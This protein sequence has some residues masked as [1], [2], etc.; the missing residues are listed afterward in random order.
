[1]D[2]GQEANPPT[3]VAD[4]VDDHVAKLK[5]LTER[6]QRQAGGFRG[7]RGEVRSSSSRGESVGFRA[8]LILAFLL[9]G[10]GAALLLAARS[11]PWFQVTGG[12]VFS[13]SGRLSYTEV[14][15]GLQLRDFGQQLGLPISAPSPITRWWYEAGLDVAMVV[16][17]L[18]C[19]VVLSFEWRSKMGA[20]VGLIAFA[21]WYAFATV[22]MHSFL[23]RGGASVDTGAGAACAGIGIVAIGLALGVA[24]SRMSAEP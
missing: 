5:E 10:V 15:H 24:P 22:N 8:R 23:T 18:S 14:A 2:A 9:L 21:S 16:V 12:P 3:S 17:L 1:M 20:L 6:N 4:N 13:L 19:G 11:Q 7:A